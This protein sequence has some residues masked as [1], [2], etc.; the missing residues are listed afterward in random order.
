M[1][2]LQN[3][4]LYQSEF[5]FLM[6]A[7]TYVLRHRGRDKHTHTELTPKAKQLHLLQTLSI[8]HVFLKCLFVIFPL[9]LYR[10]EGMRE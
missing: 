2:A 6:Q 7:V 1:L 9:S 10:E 3:D 4:L 8:L 5:R